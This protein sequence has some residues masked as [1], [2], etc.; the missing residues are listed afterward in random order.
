MERVKRVRYVRWGMMS[1]EGTGRG[2]L[3]NGGSRTVKT[4]M[5]RS[6]F[7]WWCRNRVHA[8]LVLNMMVREVR[9]RT[10]SKEML[11]RHII[12]IPVPY[13]LEDMGQRSCMPPPVR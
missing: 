2:K 7:D 10:H 13:Q 11:A 8:S 9:K 4:G 6:V 3:K 5:N 12:L 1:C